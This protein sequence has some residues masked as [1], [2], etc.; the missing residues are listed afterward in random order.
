MANQEQDKRKYERFETEVK[1]Y[2]QVSYDVRTVV[3]FQIID[4]A[5]TQT[6]S[7]KYVALS[8]NVSAE[9]LCFISDQRLEKED[10]LNLE[11][12]LP[13]ADSPILMTGKVCWS[14]KDLLA[15]EKKER[16]TTGIQ[17]LTVNDQAVGKSICFD[18]E[19][20]VVWSV[21]LESIFGSF[22]VFMQ[23]TRGHSL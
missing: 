4:K 15:P 22:R 19:N 18:K 1:I 6:K 23:K 14:Q 9:G 11:V 16:F 20:R 7:E 21:V 2:F 10:I 17:L 12:F 5:N 3:K 8:K 13:Q